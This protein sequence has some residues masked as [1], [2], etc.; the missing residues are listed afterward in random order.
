MF[1]Q[2]HAQTQHSHD[3]APGARGG[4]LEGEQNQWELGTPLVL[5]YLSDVVNLMCFHQIFGEKLWMTEISSVRWMNFAIFTCTHFFTV[6]VQQMSPAWVVSSWGPI[7]PLPHGLVSFWGI[8]LVVVTLVPNITTPQACRLHDF[9][10]VGV[11]ENE[12][13]G[14]MM[15]NQQILGACSDKPEYVVS[16]PLKTVV[17]SNCRRLRHQLQD[18]WRHARCTSNLSFYGIRSARSK[19]LAFSKPC[20]KGL[21]LPSVL[22]GVRFCGRWSVVKPNILF[23]FVENNKIITVMVGP[24]SYPGWHSGKDVS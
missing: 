17:A 5:G 24:E 15:I 13:Y 6:N 11:P 9:W 1:G 4:L 7:A 21:Q 3:F 14:E 10:T 8:A 18:M 19:R 16:Q 23:F 2:T 12:V 22:S 20:G